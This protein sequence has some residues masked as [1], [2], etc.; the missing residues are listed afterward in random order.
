MEGEEITHLETGINISKVGNEAKK[1]FGTLL[2]REKNGLFYSK[3]VPETSRECSGDIQCCCWRLE[4][5][6]N[7]PWKAR[8]S[9]SHSEFQTTGQKGVGPSAMGTA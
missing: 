3:Q 4:F 9:L 8:E 7:P 1:A 5:T 6:D 2:P